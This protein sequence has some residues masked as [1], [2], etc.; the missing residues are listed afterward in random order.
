MLKI[1]IFSPNAVEYGRGGEISSME[2]AAGLN[3]YYDVSFMD[4]SISPGEKLLSK[5]AIE[6][7]LQGTK[8]YNQMK[9]ASFHLS[10]WTFNFPYPLE[11]LKL[12]RKIKKNDI[13]YTSY[14]D[15]K[16]SLLFALSNLIF[17]NTKLIIG[18]RKPLYSTKLVSIYNLK[19]RSSILLLSLF[20]KRIYHHALS[21]HAKK[22]L[23]TFYP[24]E[25]VIHIIHGIRL[26]DFVDST[27]NNKQKD[28]L[29]FLYVG[30]L[31]DKPKGFGVLIEGIN[32]F[33][34]E[35]KNLKVYF[36]FCG[37]G[38]LKEK[39]KK[40]ERKFPDSIKYHGY[41]SN[42]L[43]PE[44]YKKNDVLLFS[45]RREPFPRVIMESLAGNLVVMCSKT[46]GSIEL[47]GGKEFAFFLKELTPGEIK[48]RILEIYNLWKDN[49][50]YFSKLQELSKKYVFKNY[51][52][53]IEMK[54]FRAL[55]K[56]IIKS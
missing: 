23:L 53:D 4:T 6:K 22:F 44:I 12:F 46:I 8:K 42:E 24:Q 28:V 13:I 21:L 30:E 55:I 25:K 15:L 19:Y 18:Y 11:I 16:T 34:K 49:Y 43:I 41:V 27:L 33:L 17:K 35:H 45:S 14:S 47:L 5:E 39:L 50:E 1:F 56:K 9:F 54:G 2:L 37:L 32:Q 26:D 48:E 40:L 10:N 7:K 38:P 51:S 20:K 31:I 29:N 36:E 3:K 52:H